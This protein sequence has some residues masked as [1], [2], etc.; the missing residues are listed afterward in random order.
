LHFTICVLTYPLF[1]RT[2]VAL[3]FSAQVVFCATAQEKTY[4][5]FTDKKGQSIEAELVSIDPKREKVKIQRKDGRH[6]E[7]AILTLSLDD[8]LYIRDWLSKV[9][10]NSKF[11]L[12][13]N[14]TRHQE[15][16]TR[17]D[18][19]NYDLK[20]VTDHVAM[21]IKVHNLSR[22]DLNG[23]LMEYYVLTEQG[24]R[25]QPYDEA[26]SK[27]YGVAEWWYSNEPAE[28]PKREKKKYEKPLLLKH[29]KV[30][31]ENLAYNFAATT[32]TES[33]PLRTIEGDTSA[34]GKDTVLGVIVKVSTSDG[35]E[36]S[37]YRSS[38]H[39]ILKESWDKIAAMPPG[40]PLGNPPVPAP[41]G[42]AS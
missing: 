14:V 30:K 15:S 29:G 34:K 24:V 6:F 32:K 27:Q 22:I 3:V 19:P 1:I 26:T 23:A 10:N 31:L 28:L 37:L 41:Q 36:L 42:P 12:E 7:I 13:I 18:V 40:D 16:T 9:P 21:E 35:K 33:I 20:W 11:K 39:K 4:H 8:Q 2:L 25:S 17:V 5:S 38:D